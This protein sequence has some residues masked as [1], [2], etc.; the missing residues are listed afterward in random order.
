[1]IC[2]KGHGNI[3]YV[4]KS[5]TIFHILTAEYWALLCAA[6][7][8]G[9]LGYMPDRTN[10]ISFHINDFI[11]YDTTIIVTAVLPTLPLKIY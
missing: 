1:V 8:E 6:D 10:F 4:V 11:Q 7:L 2:L 9:H 3:K 5:I